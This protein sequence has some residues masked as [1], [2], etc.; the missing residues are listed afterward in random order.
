MFSL[1]FRAQAFLPCEF[2]IYPFRRMSKPPAIGKLDGPTQS[3]QVVF[4]ARQERVDEIGMGGNAISSV[5]GRAA[6]DG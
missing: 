3:P 1:R 4:D 6:V 2:G 5:R